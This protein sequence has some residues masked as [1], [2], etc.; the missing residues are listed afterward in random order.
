MSPHLNSETFNPLAVFC[1]EKGPDPSFKRWVGN[2]SPTHPDA[3][4]MLSDW[5]SA[6]KDLES[7]P[8]I[9]TCFFFFGKS[10][11]IWKAFLG[12]FAKCV[13][14]GDRTGGTGRVPPPNLCVENSPFE[15]VHSLIS[16]GLI[17][18]SIELRLISYWFQA[19]FTK[20]LHSK[21]FY[22]ITQAMSCYLC[23]LDTL[24]CL[25]QT[26]SYPLLPFLLGPGLFSGANLQLVS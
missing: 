22:H 8:K 20:I 26:K 19:I 1:Q 5:S 2:I 3:S 11:R 17:V 10:W 23:L 24:P 7:S 13:F 6:F 25:P 15:N 12:V 14:L 16:T 9:A 4:S 18:E 21:I